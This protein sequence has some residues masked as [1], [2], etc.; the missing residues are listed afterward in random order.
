MHIQSLSITD[1]RNL[2]PSRLHFS[3]RLNIIFGNN[4]AGKTSLL[5]AL[6][7]IGHGRSFR[8]NKHSKL[9]HSDKDS[10]TLFAELQSNQLPYRLGIQRYRNNDWSMKLNQEPLSRLSKLVSLAPVQVL[11]PEHYDLLTKGPS[12]RRKLLDWGVFHVEHAFLRQWQSCQK[13]ILQRNKLLKSVSSYQE[14]LPWDKQLIPLSESVTRQRA[15]YCELLAPYFK[16]IVEQFL[17]SLD[18]RIEFYSGW[19][20]SQ[21]LS[22]ILQEQ[23]I[24]DKKLGYT[25]STVHKADL[26][27][28]TGKKLAAEYLSRG[29]LKLVITALKL[30]QLRLA[31]EKGQQYPV[32]L[33]DDIGSELDKSHQE[34]LF[35]FLAN[36]PESQ[37]IFITCVHLD[38]LK[39]LINRYNNAKLFHVEHGVFTAVDAPKANAQ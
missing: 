16:S 22:D 1:F 3:P 15:I 14:L 17:P 25:Q 19:N 12:G 36:Q 11:A 9:I 26:K 29:Q 34:M 28:Y 10:F 27:I 24:K 4:A 38:P 6:Y 7:V 2:Q 20:S 31:Q 23:F 21:A 30:A 18:L 5:E 35:N 8:T 39:S 37:Q 32:F 13:L 33:L